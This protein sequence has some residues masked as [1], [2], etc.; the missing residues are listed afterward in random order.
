VVSEPG[1]TNRPSQAEIGDPLGGVGPRG[2]V[3]SCAEEQIAALDEPCMLVQQKV[4]KPVS[5]AG[6]YRGH[7]DE[8]IHLILRFGIRP[9]DAEDLAQ[10][11]FMIAHQR[12]AELKELERPGAWLRGVTLRV[13][14][15]HFRW[16]KV[17][18]VAS[19]IVEYSWAAE[20]YDLHT[21]EV[22]ASTE[23]TLSQVRVVLGRM[24]DKLREAMV[25]LNVEGMTPREAAC[26]L[27]VPENTMRSRRILAR[28]EFARLWSQ[29]AGR[30]K[31]QHD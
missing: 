10:K 27:G 11:V 4:G 30:R 16:W 1:E 3:S 26:E 18:R 12:T 24:S 14:R 7:F 6:L 15:E 25:L 21:P 8:V 23:Q 29:N 2:I 28:Q 22:A 13:V 5:F 9:A 31:G 17:R 19:W 20:E